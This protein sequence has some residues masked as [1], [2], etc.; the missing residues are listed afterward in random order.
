VTINHPTTATFAANVTAVMAVGGVTITRSTDSAVATAGPGG[1]G[2]AKKVY[3]DAFITIAESA[4]NPLNQPHTFTVTATA[5]PNGAT[6]VVFNSITTT[7]KPAPG[8]MSSTCATPT[9]NGNT[10]TCTLTI[11]SGVAGQFI[12]NATANVSIGGT[13]LVRSTDGTVAIAGPGGS[14]PATK[15][16]EVLQVLGEVIT[17][18][19]APPVVAPAAPAL[20]KTGGDIARWIAMGALLIVSGTVLVLTGRLRRRRTT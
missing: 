19:P 7:V 16:Y 8:T 1:S 14:G 2:P 20:P 10:A 15:T 12:A 6:P 11:N 3:V 13:A 4:V 18:A 5:I 9:V 17:P